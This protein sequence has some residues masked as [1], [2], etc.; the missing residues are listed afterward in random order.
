MP[1]GTITSIDTIALRLPLDTWA[2]P[3]LFAGR[4]RT[5][6]DMLLVRVATSGGVIGWG[7]A[8]YGSSSPM[9]PVVFNSWIKH[10]AIGQDA[11]DQGLTARLESL[12]HVVGRC[13]PVVHAIA[14]ST[15]PC[16]I[17]AASSKASRYPRCSAGCGENASRPT[18]RCCNT[19]AR[20]S[21][22]AAMSGARS[23]AAI[24]T[25]SCMSG[26]RRRSPPPAP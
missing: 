22:C 13:G 21:M 16:G 7:E 4:P 20:A 3:P 8:C 23:N 14:D 24:A 15:S 26:P 5:H 10:V 11:T 18:P 19:G 2:P 25:S 9:I 17:S 12:R 1:A 6:V